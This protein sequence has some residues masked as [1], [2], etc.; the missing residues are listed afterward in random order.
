MTATETCTHPGCGKRQKCKKLCGMHYERQRKHGDASV[1]LKPGLRRGERTGELTSQWKGDA[2]GLDAQHKRVSAV[3]GVPKRCD[4]CG[5]T[6]PCRYYH[7]AF[8]NTGSRFNVWDYIRLCAA[9]H[10]IYDD[11]YCPRGSKHG[12]AKLAEGD[13][14]RI[15]AMRSEGRVLREI[16]ET[17][18]V[19]VQGIHDVLSGKTWSHVFSGTA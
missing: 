4:H 15:F 11:A 8:D 13:I 3:R 10:R 19:T 2:A 18:G 7:W 9:C 5:T 14:P 6:D 12:M 1:V 17:F 16:A